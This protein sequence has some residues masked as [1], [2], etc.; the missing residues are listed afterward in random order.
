[1]TSLVLISLAFYQTTYN[2]ATNV[3]GAV[4]WVL[5][6]QNADG[7]FGGSLFE[8]AL[9][10]SALIR[11]TRNPQATDAASGYIRSAQRADG[12]WNANAFETALALQACGIVR[13]A[14]RVSATATT[15]ATRPT[16]LAAPFT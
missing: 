13:F 10:Y 15:C 1:M 8:T 4:H 16:A 5:T 14:S 3:D 11:P 9:A 6:H 12:S 2:V 7:S